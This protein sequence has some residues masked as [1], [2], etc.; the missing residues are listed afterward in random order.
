MSATVTAT[1]ATSKAADGGAISVL[2]GEKYK[3]AHLLPTFPPDEHY[4]P[5][6]PFDHVDPGS[7]A[8]SHPNQ[9]AFLANAKVS[10]LTPPIG[11][12]VRGVNL[13]TLTNDEK[14][15][16]A[17]EV[18]VSMSDNRLR[19][20]RCSLSFRSRV[21]RLSSSVASRTSSTGLRNSISSGVSQHLLAWD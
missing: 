11:E 6:T 17:L 4:P 12:E 9:R 19:V 2:A 15:E 10:Q 18:S 3:Y 20:I 16:L 7:R 1:E 5:L 21:A 8:L 13:A 14:D